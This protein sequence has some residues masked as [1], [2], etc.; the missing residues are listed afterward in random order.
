MTNPIPVNLPFERLQT[1]ARDPGHGEAP[2]KL[3]KLEC[4][5]RGGPCSP[6]YPPQIP[7]ETP[8]S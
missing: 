7:N 4:R 3:Q 8:H 2:T 5:L 1:C 6:N